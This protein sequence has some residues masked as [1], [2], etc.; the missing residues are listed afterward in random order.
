MAHYLVV[1][2]ALPEPTG[3]LPLLRRLLADDAAAALT[4]LV[5]ATHG[6]GLLGAHTPA[7]E[8]LARGWGEEARER[9][10]EGGVYL[11]RVLP[12]D[13]NAATAV[14][15][16][17]RAHPDRYDAVVLCTPRARGMRGWVEGDLRASI[18]Q[19][20]PLPVF[21]LFDGVATPWGREPR[22]RIGW[23]SRLWERTRFASSAEEPVVPSRRQML[24]FYALMALYLL[25]GL[26]LAVFVN[27]G[28]L[29]NDAV[30]A[31]LYTVVIG[32]LLALLRREA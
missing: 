20:V 29:L 8:R 15:D 31:V 17:L 9:L 3:L 25:G 27:R 18:A 19:R 21:H 13:G 28:F 26:S 12:G 24:P 16:E 30:A 22:P 10:R 2:H 32:G 23:L 6:R 14:E 1:A 7:L 4:L 11:T 5:T